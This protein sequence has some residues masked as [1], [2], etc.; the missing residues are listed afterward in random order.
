MRK[1]DIEKFSLLCECGKEMCGNMNW[2]GYYYYIH[3]LFGRENY[4]KC[5][6]FKSET[7]H[8]SEADNVEGNQERR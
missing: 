8:S 1:V 2:V 5:D 3:N 4:G 6:R 7:K